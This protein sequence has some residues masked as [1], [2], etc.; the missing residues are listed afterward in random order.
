MGTDKMNTAK[1]S[2]FIVIAVLVDEKIL[3][4]ASVTLLEKIFRL[5]N[6]SAFSRASVLRLLISVTL[7]N[8]APVDCS[9]TAV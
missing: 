8:G 5:G 4:T 6:A 2:V 1:S 3:P 7:P 9:R